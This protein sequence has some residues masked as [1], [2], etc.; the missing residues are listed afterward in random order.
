MPVSWSFFLSQ[1]GVGVVANHAD[2]CGDG[3]GQRNLLAAHACLVGVILVG[4]GLGRT[5]LGAQ[6]EHVAGIGE[7]LGRD[8]REGGHLT[9]FDDKPTAKRQLPRQQRDQQHSGGKHHQAGK[10][11]APPVDDLR[12]APDIGGQGAQRRHHWANFPTGGAQPG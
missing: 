1:G 7:R 11:N 2:L 5:L 10:A 6:G 8:H 3:A 9:R 12:P 4:N